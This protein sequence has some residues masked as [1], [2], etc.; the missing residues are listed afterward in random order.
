MMGMSWQ[1]LFIRGMRYALIIVVLMI[2]WA[3]LR[4]ALSSADQWLHKKKGEAPPEQRKTAYGTDLLTFL[5]IAA[6]TWLTWKVFHWN[7]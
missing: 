5:I 1:E 7:S 6:I 3:A 2:L 4:R